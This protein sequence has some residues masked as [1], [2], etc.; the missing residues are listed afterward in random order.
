MARGA[1][2]NGCYWLWAL[3]CWRGWGRRGRWSYTWTNTANGTADFWTNGNFW[4]TPANYPGSNIYENAFLTN[5]TVAG[6]SYTTIL[7]RALIFS[8]GTLTISNSTDRQAWLIITNTALSGTT[9]TLG[10]GGGLEIDNGGVFAVTTALT[11]L[12]PTAWIFLTQRHLVHRR[13][14]HWHQQLGHT[15]LGH[16]HGSAGSGGMWRIQQ[17][18][19]D[20]RQHRQF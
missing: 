9:F 8:I 13:G 17:P 16:Q 20:H 18:T 4:A 5:N 12:A 14:G 10:N 3:V 19:I 15:Q 2:G 7:N 1:R 11:G 6:G